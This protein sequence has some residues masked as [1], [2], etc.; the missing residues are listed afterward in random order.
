MQTDK[1]TDKKYAKQKQSRSNC[2]K[3]STAEGR[4][5]KKE[6]MS[7]REWNTPL[8]EVNQLGILCILTL[9]HQSVVF[10]SSSA[11]KGSHD[12]FY[13]SFCVF[14]CVWVWEGK[15][16]RCGSLLCG[17]TQRLQ[18]N[19]GKTTTNTQTRHDIIEETL[20]QNTHTH[21][22]TH[23]RVFLFLIGYPAEIRTQDSV[24]SVFDMSVVYRY[25]YSNE[26]EMRRG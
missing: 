17:G 24:V 22:H 13:M 6:Q 1:Q 4:N 15:K 10:A 26:R 23:V 20:P 16:R 3:R 5:R 2:G 12:A 8:T 19:G 18:T 21:I 7:A 14:V 9:S 25:S 11:K